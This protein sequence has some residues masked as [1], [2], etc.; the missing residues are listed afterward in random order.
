MLIHSA[1]RSQYSHVLNS[2]PS[3]GLHSVFVFPMSFQL[4]LKTVPPDSCC[5]MQNTPQTVNYKNCAMVYVT[6]CSVRHNHYDVTYSAVSLRSNAYV[7]QM[8]GQFFSVQYHRS[9]IQQVTN[10]HDEFS[11]GCLLSN[12]DR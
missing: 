1:G 4:V 9:K 8:P 7:Q 6:E 11:A 12:I 3:G 5:R 2:M 10:I